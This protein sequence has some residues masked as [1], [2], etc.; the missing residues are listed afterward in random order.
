MQ[1]FH[2]G[3][4]LLEA[5][6]HFAYVRNCLVCKDRAQVDDGGCGHHV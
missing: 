1:A 5:V 6:E 4:G 3:H 2:D